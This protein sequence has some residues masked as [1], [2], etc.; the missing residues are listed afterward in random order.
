MP[1][2]IKS[3]RPN[4][5]DKTNHQHYILA[6]LMMAAGVTIIRN[7]KD[8][9]EL[10]SRA[11]MLDVLPYNVETGERVPMTP[12]EFA[13][14]LLTFGNVTT[15]ASPRTAAS[16]AKSAREAHARVAA[17]AVKYANTN[18]IEVCDE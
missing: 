13:Q 7:D 15:N 14:W 8:R 16:V 5:N 1:L 17:A 18:P 11:L 12:Q 6:T 3:D 9:A 2:T 10:L 4:I